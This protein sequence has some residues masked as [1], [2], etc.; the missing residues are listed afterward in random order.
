MIFYLLGYREDWHGINFKGIFTSYD[1]A[2][3]SLKK[4][5]FKLA[6]DDSDGFVILPVKVNQEVLI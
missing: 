5:G 2:L 4:H 3:K 1:N 6:E